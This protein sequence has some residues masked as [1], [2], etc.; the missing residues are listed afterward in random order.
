M[1][2]IRLGELLVRAGHL[3]ED[4][5]AR[6]LQE[7]KRWGG[8]LGRILREMNLVTEEI[9]LKALTKQLG[10]PRADLRAPVIPAAVLAS[11]DA[12]FAMEHHLCPERFDAQARTLQIAMEDHLN[13]PALDEIGAKTG[14]RIKTSLATGAEIDAGLAL[15]YPGHPAVGPIR[16]EDGEAPA[17]GSVV[18]FE[19]KDF[20]KAAAEARELSTGLK[21]GNLRTLDTGDFSEAAGQLKHE[22]AG[23]AQP[24]RMKYFG[25]EDFSDAARKVRDDDD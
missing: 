17:R 11:I 1:A 5:L 16:S 21:K 9:L 15:L 8:R 12:G 4:D 25:T 13:L 14:A 10:L 19:T 2:H 22:T 3:T 6:A 18:M 20:S 7:Q 23:P 24:D